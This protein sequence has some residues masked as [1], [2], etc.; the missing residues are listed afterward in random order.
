MD[1]NKYLSAKE[2]AQML[3]VPMVTV[4]RWA[5][6]GKVPC[7]IKDEEYLFK[8][9]EMVTWAGTHNFSLEKNEKTPPAPPEEEYIS[10]TKALERGGFFYNV[11]G[12][13]IYSVLK[14][15]VDVIPLPEGTNKEQVLNELLNREEIASTGI[16][17]G[18]AIPHPRYM[19]KLDLDAPVIFV[20]F[21]EKPVDFNALDGVGVSVLFMIFS[22]STHFHLKL[23]SRLSHCLR[24]ESFLTLLNDKAGE[25]KLLTEIQR[26]EKQF[27]DKPEP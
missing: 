15:A 7:L 9:S 19:L 18:V 2:V 23:L 25:Q 5:H 6:Q 3:G 24:E 27:E 8:H 22:P 12:N 17:K 13:D 1:K 21:L 10:L 20:I 26:I 11:A 4:Q 14:N 16:G